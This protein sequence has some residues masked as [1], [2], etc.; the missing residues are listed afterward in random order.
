M[1]IV[2]NTQQSWQDPWYN[3]G[4]IAGLVGH[5]MYDNHTRKQARKEVDKQKEQELYAL[6]KQQADAMGGAWQAYNNAKDKLVDE[7]NSLADAY[8]KNQSQDNYNALVQYVK[9]VHPGAEINENSMNDALNYV[10]SGQASPLQNLRTAAQQAAQTIN[11][12]VDLTSNT[13]GTDTVNMAN[14]R[15]DYTKNFETF[16]QGRRIGGKG[17]KEYKGSYDYNQMNPYL[18]SP[19]GAIGKTSLADGKPID[20][21]FSMPSSNTMTLQQPKPMTGLFDYGTLTQYR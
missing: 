19:Y 12:Y 10:K 4:Q 8:N 21:N 3:L 9:K 1:L 18:A 15:A 14:N 7:G 11:P 17:D 5:K 20:L 2:P 16:N 6:Q 13:W